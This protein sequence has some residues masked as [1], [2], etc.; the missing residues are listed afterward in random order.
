MWSKNLLIILSNR[1]TKDLALLEKVVYPLKIGI[2]LQTFLV[3]LNRIVRNGTEKE[4]VHSPKSH[5]Q[6]V[7]KY[8]NVLQ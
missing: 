6:G 2:F 7:C 5:F 8:S 3:L 4:A 1:L